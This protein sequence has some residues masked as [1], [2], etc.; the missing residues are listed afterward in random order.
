[1]EGKVLVTFASK[2]DATKEIAE[3]IGEVIGKAGLN[4]EVL[5]VDVVQDVKQ[6]KAVI[7]GSAIY[8]GNWPK[9]AVAFLKANQQ[10]LANLP[11]WIFSSGP[12]GEGNPIDLVEGK[13]LPSAVKPVT[14]QIKP[15]DITIF[16]GNIDPDKL[17]FIEKWAIKSLVKKPFGDYRDW[18]S[19]SAW[20]SNIATELKGAKNRK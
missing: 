12:S 9:K 7:F 11:V 2:Y 8:V 14:D 4:S 20:T 15:R 5:A 18:T 6:Y 1:M 13:L 19:I 10:D 17:N 16:H 3:K